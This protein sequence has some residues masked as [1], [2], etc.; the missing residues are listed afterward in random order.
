MA[1]SE[2]PQRMEFHMRF[3]RT[4]TTALVALAIG[5]VPFAGAP[6]AQA[7]TVSTAHHSYGARTPAVHGSRPVVTGTPAVG[8]TLTAD[9]GVWTPSGVTLAYQWFRGDRKVVGATASTYA[10]TTADLH[11]RLTVKVTG[12][13]TGYR[14][15]SR[16]SKPTARVSYPALTAVKPVISGSATAQVGVALTADPGAWGPSGVV[17]SYQWFRSGHRIANATTATYTP[18]AKDWRQRLTV[19]VTGKLAGYATTSRV[20]LPTAKVAA[21]VLT[22]TPVPTITGTAAVGQVLTAV[23]GTWG[24]GTVRFTYQWYRSGVR[25]R[26]ADHRTYTVRAADAGATL[27]VK[28]TG[29]KYGYQPI[30]E[31]SAPTAVVA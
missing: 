17:L 25:I 26:H 12:S 9:P 13:E 8:A 28:V 18:V 27:T 15:A 23:P 2:S 4:L 5:F 20:S 22:P 14:S 7:G 24:P 1:E 19:K 29:W 3:P 10:V 31:V 11:K 30:V 21:G 6:A 16:F